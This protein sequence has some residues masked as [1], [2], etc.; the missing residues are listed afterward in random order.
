MSS[1]PKRTEDSNK[2]VTNLT[3][4]FSYNNSINNFQVPNQ[5]SQSIPNV[6]NNA[7]PI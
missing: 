2:D 1:D 4:N 6:S 3:N 7:Q 5:P